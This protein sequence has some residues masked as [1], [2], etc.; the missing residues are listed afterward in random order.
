[1]DGAIAGDDDM[2]VI[3][4]RDAGVTPP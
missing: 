2:I 3:V 4:R 1:M